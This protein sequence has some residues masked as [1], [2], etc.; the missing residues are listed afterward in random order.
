[1]DL[2]K[3]NYPN[4]SKLTI[5]IITLNRKKF[6]LRTMNYWSGSNIKLLVVDGSKS[7]IEDHILRKFS[8]NITYFHQPY[9]G[10]QRVLFALKLVQTEFVILGSDD[11]YFVPSALNSCV[12]TLQQDKELAACI[13]RAV[14]FNFKN[15][16]MTGKDV[17]SI[18]KN[19]KLL[20]DDPM[21]RIKKLFR[22]F[23]PFH[24]HAVC[25]SN[26]WKIAWEY[27]CFK[28]YNFYGSGEYFFEFL[29]AFSN[30][31]K[32]IPVFMWFRSDENESIRGQGPALTLGY[33]IQDWWYDKKYK[34]EKKDYLNR[35]ELACSKIS[36]INKK[37]YIADVIGGHEI[38][39]NFCKNR[40]KLFKVG[41]FSYPLNLLHSIFQQLPDFITTPIKSIVRYFGFKFGK[42]YE[43]PFFDQLKVLEKE[44]VKI[45]YD[46]VQQIEKEIKL[47][48]LSK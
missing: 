42:S 6:I 9:S 23:M 5:V 3:F 37:N 12:E 8:N 4:L 21:I 19:Y 36:E 7:P 17:Y 18:L 46:E 20:D 24:C 1:M 28:E 15:N 48:Y 35:I 47:F 13:G 38:L 29:M 25:R 11:E 16:Q 43:L 32:S 33:E 10:H 44:G 31:S 26:F 14:K 39:I 34:E 40:S 22:N 45:D 27:A 41:L 30:K 2:K